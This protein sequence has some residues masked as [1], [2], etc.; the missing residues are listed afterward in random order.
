MGGLET[1]VRELVPALVKARPELE[2]VVYA[3]DGARDALRA[4]TW[5]ESAA[6]ATHPLL[7]RRYTRAAS[8]ATLLG[9]VA[10]RDRLDVLHNVAMTAPLWLRPANVVMVADMTWLHEPGAVPRHVRRLWWSL[11]RPLVR[12]ANRVVT[13]SEA[14]RKEIVAATRADHARIDVIPLATSSASTTEATPVDEI[15]TQLGIGSGPLVLAVSLLRPHK[16]LGRLI[17]AWQS[18]VG[19]VPDARLVIAGSETSFRAELLAR[20]ARLGVSDSVSFPGWVSRNDLEGLYR[21]AT[22]FVFPSLREGFGIPLLEAMERDV[23]IACSAAS[24]MP[25]VAGD[26][27]LYF[28]P[29]DPAAIAEAVRR[30]LTDARLA[31]DLIRRGR[32]QRQQFTWE[33]TATKTLASLDRAVADRRATS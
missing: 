21:A 4:E 28:D 30:I 31:D 1:Y 5:P 7:G 24:A 20:A 29:Y 15:R 33:R 17:D 22:C 26:A 9:W 12:R 23:P 16:N 8:E 18:V 2:L 6:V 3:S 13:L 11:L 14:A 32:A 19:A 27:A 25:E 10:S